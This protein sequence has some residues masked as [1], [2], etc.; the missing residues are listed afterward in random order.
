MS[1]MRP[2]FRLLLATLAGLVLGA[3]VHITIILAM[4]SFAQRDAY[5]R[6]QSI[7]DKQKQN[8][9]NLVGETGGL[10]WLRYRDPAITMVAC[11]Y[12]LAAGPH[13]V[14][15]GSGIPFESVAFHAHQ[16]NVFFSVT[17][18]AQM[19]GQTGF[20]V[21]T[22]AQM[23]LL[24]QSGEHDEF[25]SELIKVAAPSTKGL[26]TVRTLAPS[27]SYHKLSEA[28]ATQTECRLLTAEDRVAEP[29][30]DTPIPHDLLPPRRG[31]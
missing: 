9:F 30:A 8:S 1:A 14:K 5:G 4:P 15:L 7:A 17:D 11:P 23:A 27:Y 6:L 16:G 10:T 26:A 19:R 29:E 2:L 24:V 28:A 31:R 21:A 18:Q 25:Y 12:D 13:I 3:I 22:Q 20:L